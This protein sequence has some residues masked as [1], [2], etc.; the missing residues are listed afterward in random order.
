MSST[1]VGPMIPRRALLLALLA[2]LAV[3]GNACPVPLCFSIQILLGSIASTLALLWLRGWWNVAIAA[4]ASLT[5]WTLWGHPWAILIFSAE[6][7]W[8]AVF[9]NRFSGPPENDLKGRIVLAD[10]VFWLLV[11]VPLVFFLYGSVLL[12]DPANVGVV[13][14][15]QAVNGV[16]NTVVAFLLFVLLQLRRHRRGQGLLPLRGIV[17]SVVLASITL[18]SLGITLLSCS[19]LQR[20][21]QEGVL[22]NLQT[23]AE[24][25]ARIDP[26]QLGE[27]TRGLPASIG[28]AA[29]L[30]IDSAGNQISSN[31]GLF[32]RLQNHFQNAPPDQ[33]KL[34]GLEILVP[35][36]HRLALKTWVNGYW[37]TTMTSPRYRVQVVQP[38]SPVVLKLQQ[39]STALL[40]TL[41]WVI[42][43][44]VLLSEVVAALMERQ[45]RLLISP[46]AVAATADSTAEDRSGIAEIEG[47]ATRLDENRQEAAHLRQEL[48]VVSAQLEQCSVQQRHLA[49]T[50][51]LTGAANRSELE[52]SLALISERARACSVP[53]TCLA[54]AVHG[55]RPINT[56]LGRQKGDEVL[57]QLI[58]AV[59]ERLH[60]ND[61]LFRI[62]GSE[63]L[64]LLWDQPLE[65]AR[66]TADQI[67]KIVRETALPSANGS[68]RTLAMSAGISLLDSSDTNGQA[69]LARVELALNQSRELGADQVVVR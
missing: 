35:R 62:G 22:E 8:L 24:A 32:L 55:L 29:F 39:Q 30:L 1:A 17:F 12:I 4:I 18:P 67:R 10:A 33:S 20:A 66:S 26:L 43:L 23:V 37:S 9:V 3:L 41:L 40:T 25:A 7:L 38:A 27:P 56:A 49:S 28:S 44:G 31:P 64:L 61:E 2:G 21:S 60:S 14:A 47:L 36:E 51:S 63:F 6:A 19:Q 57:Q 52:L 50:D 46:A 58:A 48:A 5:T 34:D 15:K 65:R 16:A 69:M 13:A 42:L 59:R 53:L 54:F 45:L 68:P 11:G